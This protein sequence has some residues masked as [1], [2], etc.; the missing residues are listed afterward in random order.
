MKKLLFIISVFIG[1]I[2]ECFSQSVVETS[3]FSRHPE[4]GGEVVINKSVKEV[5]DRKAYTS[6]EVE[7]AESGTYYMNLWLLAT[8][9]KD[10]TFSNYNVE[11]N[12]DT[13]NDIISP[14]ESDWQCIG[15]A[16]NTTIF[17]HSGKN[18]ISI[19]GNLPD[20][21][22]V[23][24]VRLSKSSHGAQISSSVYKQYIKDLSEISKKNALSNLSTKDFVN[25]NM[26]NDTLQT[27]ELRTSSISYDPPLYDYQYALGVSVKYTFYKTVSFTQN[28]QITIS[29]SGVDNYDHVLEFFSATSP[30]L[31]SWNAHSNSNCTASITVQIPQTGLYYV[32]VRSYWNATSGLCNLNINGENFYSNIPL[33]SIGYVCTQGTDQTYNTFTCYNSG[34]PRLWIEEYGSNAGISAYNDDYS[35]TGDF[36]WGVNARI[37]KNYTR[38]VHAVLLST[39][40]SYNPNC[41][42]DLYMRCKNNNVYTYFDNLKQDD[43]INSSA[44]SGNYNCISWSGGITSYWEWPPSPY[45]NYYSPDPLTA[46]DNFYASRGLTRQGATASNSKVDLWAIVNNGN[47]TYTHASV[48]K[49]ADPNAHG[50]DWE[51]KPGG[52]ARTFHPR[53]S[54]NGDSYGEVVEHY[55]CDPNADVIMSLDEEIANGIK[56]IENVQFTNNEINYIDNKILYIPHEL[57]NGFTF[58]MNKWKKEIENSPYSNFNQL[59]SSESYE[60]IIDLCK[61]NPVLIYL[62]YKQLGTGDIFMIKILEDISLPLN[63]E[64][65]TD[66]KKENEANKITHDG[67]EIIRTPYSNAMTY[68]KKLININESSNETRSGVTYSNEDD[69][70]ISSSG[71]TITVR[72]ST[73]SESNVSITVTSVTKLTTKTLLENKVLP[74]GN[75]EYSC[76]V[77]SSGTYLIQYKYNGNINIKKIFVE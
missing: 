41:T 6:F 39:Y 34:D 40:S 47:R 20:V 59:A 57:K 74:T 69:F 37:K 32:R 9:L 25:D 22:E 28:Q 21:P 73:K 36:S 11:V 64:L 31:Y 77:P 17:L 10:G 2:T 70:T 30:E 65:L 75:Y 56:V 8:M 33:F 55:I 27:A 1:S 52:L 68:V 26:P 63:K 16:N 24:F 54:L 15:F 35:G 51:S 72:F 7:V 38:T 43:C 50:Y 66:I 13:I 62:V 12:G 60:E 45:S 23:E 4:L 19:I 46:F 18:I 71:K 67:A 58:A 5:K 49:G 42:C 53:Y 76:S 48:R 29:T 3:Y 61:N 44:A 14:K